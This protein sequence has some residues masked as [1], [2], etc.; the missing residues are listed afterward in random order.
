MCMFIRFMVEIRLLGVNDA[1]D[2]GKQLRGGLGIVVTEGVSGFRPAPEWRDGVR[3]FWGLIWSR[4]WGVDP[5]AGVW[6][7]LRLREHVVHPTLGGRMYNV[8]PSLRTNGGA[9]VVG[10]GRM[11]NVL[12]SLRTNGE[13]RRLW[14]AVECTTCSLRSGR[15]GRGGGCGR[16]SNIQRAPFAQ[17]ERR[18]GEERWGCWGSGIA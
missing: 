17:D 15:T 12:P 7:V 18:E 8:L 2:L 13:G 14:E 3:G 11:Y 16:R 10:G 5:V 6:G 4:V 1:L 9:E